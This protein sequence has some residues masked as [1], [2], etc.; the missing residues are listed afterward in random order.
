MCTG[1]PPAKSYMPTPQGACDSDV[2]DRQVR[3]CNQPR[4]PQDQYATY[5]RRLSTWATDDAG[6]GTDTGS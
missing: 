6:R 1:P 3:L 4:A 2:V 5:T